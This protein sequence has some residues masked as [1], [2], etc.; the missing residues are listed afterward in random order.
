M[1]YCF[2]NFQVKDTKN[3]I[4]SQKEDI[5]AGKFTFSVENYDVFEICFISQKTES[6][7]FVFLN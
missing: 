1:F 6:K 2:H 4:L 3:H 5:G 7:F